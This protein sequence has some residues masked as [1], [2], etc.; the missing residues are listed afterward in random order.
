V[1]KVVV[2]SYESHQSCAIVSQLVESQC[3]EPVGFVRSTVVDPR[4]KGLR[5]VSFLLAPNRRWGVSWKVAEV[6]LARVG[7]VVRKIRGVKAVSLR[8]LAASQE[9]PCI[10][11]SDPTDPEFLRQLGH[12]QPDLLL[13]VH[14]N[15]VLKPT[16]WECAALGAINVHG[17]LLPNH[18]GLFPHFYALAA[19]ETHGGVTV[20]WIDE[21]L[22]SGAPITQAEIPIFAGDTVVELE[23]RAI[24]TSVDA[25]VRAIRC[26]ETSG[27]EAKLLPRPDGI[28]S[29]HSWPTNSDM[30]NLRRA[31]HKYL[32][33]RDI[34]ELLGMK[35]STGSSSENNFEHNDFEKHNFTDPSAEVP[36][37][38]LSGPPG[39][40]LP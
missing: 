10:D 32:N 16:T 20:H 7:G 26:I 17:G 28:T 9:V 35:R 34:V 21:R 15:H 11:C 18:R 39:Y 19:G 1:L 22:D 4:R 37:V 3:F 5:L 12:L 24:P 38:L 13:S 8:A 6:L 40:P 27:T 36:L 14:F 33:A 31:G 2:L 29:Y 23:N 30:R 25:I